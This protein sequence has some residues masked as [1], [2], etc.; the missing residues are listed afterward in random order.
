[1][2]NAPGISTHSEMENTCGGKVTQLV[3]QLAKLIDGQQ[4]TTNN[5]MV[6]F[7]RE[8]ELQLLLEI[9][10][11]MFQTTYDVLNERQKQNRRKYS[12]LGTCCFQLRELKENQQL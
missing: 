7:V 6:V 9:L 11:N 1:M 4:Y 8:K 2:Q 12:D 3:N 10:N 5:T